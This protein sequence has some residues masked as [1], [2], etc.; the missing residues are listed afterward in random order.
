MRRGEKSLVRVKPKWGYGYRKGTGV[1][2][3]PVGWDSEE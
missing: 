3:W 1:S 2:E